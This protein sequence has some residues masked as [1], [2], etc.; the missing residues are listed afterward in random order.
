M[1][2][3]II[4]AGQ[5]GR[6]ENGAVGELEPGH[7]ARRA[8]LGLELVRVLCVFGEHKERTVDVTRQFRR[9]KREAGGNDRLPNS[10]LARHEHGGCK[11][12]MRSVRS[13]GMQ[14]GHCPSSWSRD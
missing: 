1:K 3:G 5:L 10:A 7:E 8:D 12:D 9:R 6:I 2:I 13:D 14:V 4:G 11:A